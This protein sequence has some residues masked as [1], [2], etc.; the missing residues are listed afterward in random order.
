MANIISSTLDIKSGYID[1]LQGIESGEDVR[2]RLFIS[3]SGKPV[4]LGEVNIIKISVRLPDFE[5]IETIEFN[6]TLQEADV[7]DENAKFDK[8]L[9]EIDAK[10]GIVDFIIGGNFTQH[11]GVHQMQ[12]SFYRK[13]KVFISARLNYAVR[14]SI[15][16]NSEVS[17]V[18]LNTLDDILKAV[19]NS[20]TKDSELVKSE[21]A[22]VEAETARV[23]A[24]TARENA[25]S[26]RA[27]AET[28]RQSAERDRAKAEARRA[29]EL[30]DALEDVIDW[31]K[32]D[33]GSS[34]IV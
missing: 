20:L 1:V 5:A 8:T 33:G 16:A 34:I 13:D 24:E 10:N 9:Q 31:Q 15:S 2:L 19:S 7:E 18:H 28:E 21:D 22:R 14:E 25:E 26:D 4:N 30:K 3:D 23:E 12:L 11:I 29:S 6:K 27:D 17:S 32:T